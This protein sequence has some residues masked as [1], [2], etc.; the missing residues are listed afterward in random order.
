MQY[1]DVD[2]L[3]S[4]QLTVEPEEG[5][6]RGGRFIFSI[7]VPEEYNI[8]VSVFRHSL[9]KAILVS[10]RRQINGQKLRLNTCETSAYL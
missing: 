3:H 2:K 9:K 5:Y 4:L 10:K 1:E 7:Y 6:W 8:V